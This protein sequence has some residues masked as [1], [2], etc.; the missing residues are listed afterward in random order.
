MEQNN[1]SKNL[2]LFIIIAMLILLGWNWMFPPPAIEQQPTDKNVQATQNSTATSNSEK[3]ESSLATGQLVAVKTDVMNLN[4]DMQSG[5]IRDLVLTRYNATSD[6]K[7]PFVLFE[8]KPN[9][10]YVAQSGLLDANNQYIFAPFTTPKTQYQMNGD[11]LT[12]RLN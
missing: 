3:V 9:K 7:K 4:I 6:E 2:I 5:D 11:V 1:N 12:V 10:V 8:N